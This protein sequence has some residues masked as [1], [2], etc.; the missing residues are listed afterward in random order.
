MTFR[1]LRGDGEEGG[2]AVRG[3]PGW[4]HF[5]RLAW[6]SAREPGIGVGIGIAAYFV[7][8]V[9]TFPE[10]IDDMSPRDLREARASLTHVFLM[11]AFVGASAGTRLL[12]WPHLLFL[13]T[14]PVSRGRLAL[15][16][17]IEHAILVVLASPLLFLFLYL[18]TD[19]SAPLWVFI[20]SQFLI[21][22][23]LFG[24][25]AAWVLVLMKPLAK[26]NENHAFL[27]LV[28][29]IL[30]LVVYMSDMHNLSSPA[31]ANHPLVSLTGILWAA[32]GCVAWTLPF[33]LPSP[34][35]PQKPRLGFSSGNRSTQAPPLLQLAKVSRLPASVR[36]LSPFIRVA[37]VCAVV[38][39][40][41]EWFYVSPMRLIERFDHLPNLV[42]LI[43]G[44]CILFLAVWLVFMA[45]IT[46]QAMLLFSLLLLTRLLPARPGWVTLLVYGGVGILLPV[47]IYVRTSIFQLPG[48]YFEFPFVVFACVSFGLALV[49]IVIRYTLRNNMPHK[50]IEYASSIFPIF[51]IAVTLGIWEILPNP[52]F[53]VF[54]SVIIGLNTMAVNYFWR[55]A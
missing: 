42:W 34:Y 48:E 22:N 49:I 4:G 30:F 50:V 53:A 16:V 13:R 6:E 21:G 33:I 39:G 37:L 1:H 29:M 45:Y 19:A 18:S 8:C 41:I 51:G 10:Q 3:R 40:V 15:L 17:L 27:F 35:W 31:V 38:I 52:Y 47:L 9:W 44:G 7:L 11:V 46:R 24:I 23:A 55:R 32:L 20:P 26:L 2:G 14:L 54:M 25:L 5:F 12:F 28:P 43:I 36:F